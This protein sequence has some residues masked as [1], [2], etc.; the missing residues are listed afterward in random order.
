MDRPISELPRARRA[1]DGYKLRDVPDV[2]L[3][4]WLD[5]TEDGE[6]RSML[7]RDDVWHAEDFE[8][9]VDDLQEESRV[10]AADFIRWET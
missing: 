4:I 1:L 10:L 2:G 9:H 7:V 5:Y 3:S 6:R 8:T